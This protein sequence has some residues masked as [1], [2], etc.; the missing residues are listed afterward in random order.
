MWRTFNSKPSILLS[1]RRGREEAEDRRRRRICG[2]GG[3]QIPLLL[4]LPTLLHVSL[5]T[6]ISSNILWVVQI[7]LEAILGFLGVVSSIAC[8]GSDKSM[9]GMVGSECNPSISGYILNFSFIQSYK[10]S[11]SNQC[12][13]NIGLQILIFC[14]LHWIVA[15][16]KSVNYESNRCWIYRWINV[17]WGLK[18]CKTLK[19]ILGSHHNP[20]K[21]S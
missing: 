10:T 13:P 6:C 14:F 9:V 8:L 19:G 1:C 15:R 21:S 16:P 20:L 4:Q 11:T 18:R 12:V 2:D 7:F 5:A 17:G 3:V